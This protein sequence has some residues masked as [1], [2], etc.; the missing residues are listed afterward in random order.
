MARRPLQLSVGRTTFRGPL[1]GGSH[2]ALA[3]DLKASLDG[4]L[5]NMRQ[6]IN[7]IEG[8]TPEIL[9]EVLQPTF[10]KSQVL[11]PVKNGTLKASGYLETRAGTRTAEVE[12]GYGRGGH[13]DYAIFVHEIPRNHEEPT[14]DKFLQVPVEEDLPTFAERLAS[15]VREVVGT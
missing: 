11:C 3:A 13:P 2:Q 12:M 15:K 1:S 8:S 14:R 6:V 9:A 10:D 5:G 7:V 4:V